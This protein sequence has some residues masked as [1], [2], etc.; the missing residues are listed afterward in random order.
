MTCDLVDKGNKGS[1]LSLPSSLVS[2]KS[3]GSLRCAG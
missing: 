3:L 2:K 1:E